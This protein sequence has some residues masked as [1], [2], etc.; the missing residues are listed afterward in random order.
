MTFTFPALLT[1]SPDCTSPRAAGLK[2]MGVAFTLISCAKCLPLSVSSVL[3]AGA[4]ASGSEIRQLKLKKKNLKLRMNTL[5]ILCF[6]KAQ[7][8]CHYYSSGLPSTEE[9]LPYYERIEVPDLFDASLFLFI[10]GS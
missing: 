2:R 4:L 5:T 7:A 3:W 9:C 6:V 8:L 1:E 10:S